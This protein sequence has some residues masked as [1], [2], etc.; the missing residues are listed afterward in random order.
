MR[1]VSA[2][3][4]G[5]RATRFV[6]VRENDAN[7]LLVPL[8]FGLRVP[9]GLRVRVQHGTAGAPKSIEVPDLENVVLYPLYSAVERTSARGTIS[10][11]LVSDFTEKQRVLELLVRLHYRRHA[12]G[13]ILAAY[14]GASLAGCAVLSRLTFGKPTRRREYLETLDPRITEKVISETPILWVRRFASDTKFQGCGIGTALAKHVRLMALNY[15]R[16]KPVLIEVI[17]SRSMQSIEK[18]GP[19]LRNDFLIRAGYRLFGK[20]WPEKGR[21]EERWSNTRNCFEKTRVQYF[22]Y[23]CRL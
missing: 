14:S 16:P 5:F 9:N 22:Y 1:G 10:I 7:D 23:V 19:V 11:R 4:D 3:I 18:H 2:Q 15:F 21:L 6:L 12:N 8:P 13:M 17:T 20:P